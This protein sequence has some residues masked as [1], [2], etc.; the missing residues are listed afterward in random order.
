MGKGDVLDL[1]YVRR[2]ALDWPSH[3]QKRSIDDRVECRRLF[4]IHLADRI[5]DRYPTDY[6]Y[7]LLTSETESSRH[8]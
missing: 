1:P 7:G 4:S 5:C 3:L 6:R 8:M 2:D